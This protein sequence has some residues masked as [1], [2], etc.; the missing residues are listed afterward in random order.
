M[1]D[2]NVLTDEKLFSLCRMYGAQALEAR[3]K[4]LGLLP[5]VNRRRLYEK[6]GFSSI[7]IFA[8]QLAG[9]SEEQVRRVLNL[10]KKFED[11]PVL[12]QALTTGAIS[13]NKLARIASVATPE[14]ESELTEMAKNLPQKALEVFAKEER[15]AIGCHSAENGNALQKPLFDDESVRA[16]RSC[17]G[18]PAGDSVTRK[19]ELSQEVQEKL[20][21]LKEKGIDVDVLLMELLAN[22]EVEIFRAKEQI[23]AEIASNDAVNTSRHIPVRVERVLSQE[24]GKKCSVPNCGHDAETLH[25]T[26]RF[27][28]NRAHDPRFLAPLCREHHLLAHAADVRFW[29][30]R[31]GRGVVK[32]GF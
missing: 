24:Y 26:Q 13:V 15:M 28:V 17:A 5:E 7:F 18:A 16:H 23:S 4:F 29:E 32:T 8:Y 20:W 31:R 10:E 25:H 30:R 9:A 22:R 27:A 3:R 21:E 14:N 11:K 6:K 19:V 2:N 12:R 1:T